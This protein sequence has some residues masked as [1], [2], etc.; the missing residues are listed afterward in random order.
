ME[1]S[2]V[3]DELERIREDLNRKIHE[4]STYTEEVRWARDRDVVADAIEYL[5]QYEDLMQ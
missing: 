4:S 3:I 1:I 5:W 2:N